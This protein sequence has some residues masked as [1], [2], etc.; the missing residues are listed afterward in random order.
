MAEDKFE[1]ARTGIQ[2]FIEGG[3]KANAWFAE[4]VVWDFS[5]FR[6]WI[7]DSQYVGHEAF[8]R[9][10]ARWTE[11]FETYHWEFSEILDA[12]GDDILALGWQRGTLKGS[13]AAVEMPLAQ[14]LTIRDGKLQRLRI[15]ADHDDARAAAG[16]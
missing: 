9:Q 7:E 13:G 16:L 12:G 6:G 10:V 1:I 8:D 15:F 11:P 4:D 14:L 3:E 5:G 2:A